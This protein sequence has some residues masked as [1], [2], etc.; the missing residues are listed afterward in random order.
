METILY[1]WRGFSVPSLNETLN[2]CLL[3]FHYLLHIKESSGVQR[4]FGD[5]SNHVSRVLAWRERCLLF[6]LLPKIAIVTGT[7]KRFVTY[8]ITG[9]KR[10]PEET[11]VHVVLGKTHRP[12]SDLGGILLK[13]PACFWWLLTDLQGWHWGPNL[14]RSALTYANKITPDVIPVFEDLYDCSPQFLCLYLSLY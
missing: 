11:V 12:S 4:S 13:T 1:G 3:Y 14:C 6:G 7:E 2:L 8:V 10:V 9:L 5:V